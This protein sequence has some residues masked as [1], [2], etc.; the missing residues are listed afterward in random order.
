M[1]LL[2]TGGLGYI[3]SHLC[4]ELLK[5]YSNIVV[6]DNLSNSNLIT[7]KYIEKITNKKIRFIKDDL[8]NSKNI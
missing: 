3:G 6:L 7:K 5:K 2:I 8:S 4:V 1:N